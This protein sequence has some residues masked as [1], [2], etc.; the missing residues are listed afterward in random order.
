MQN[1]PDWVLKYKT[2]GIYVKKT[3]RGTPYIG[4]TSIITTR[5]KLILASYRMHEEF[6]NDEHFLVNLLDD[7]FSSTV[8]CIQ[9]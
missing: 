4:G 9:R 6:L 3:R 5:K 2:K 1:L 8:F 7:I